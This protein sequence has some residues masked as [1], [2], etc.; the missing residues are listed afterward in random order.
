ME[1]RAHGIIL[2]TR[3][4]TETS[5]V[6]QWLTVEYGRIATAAKGARRAKSPFRGKLDLFFE[7][8]FTYVLSRR[9]SLHTL[10]EFHLTDTHS[11]LRHDLGYLQ[12]A[13]YAAALLEQA[14]ESDTPLPAVHA[15]FLGFLQFLGRAAASPKGIFAF[16]LKL[17][18]ELGLRPEFDEASVSVGS[19]KVMQH[20]ADEPWE[21][22][23]ALELNTSQSTE[24]RQFLHGFLIFHLGKF[25]ASRAGALHP[26]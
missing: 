15:L 10:K 12:Q 19:K 24:I 25:P 11:A 21:Q 4:L 6:V 20:L 16:E 22:I 9:S 8:E 7:G 17:L 1:L 5:L 23:F 2:R 3:L 13:S 18:Q 26:G 14:T